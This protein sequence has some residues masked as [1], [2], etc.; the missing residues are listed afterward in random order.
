[1]VNFLF[2]H[3][4]TTQETT[5]NPFP[6]HAKDHDLF[7]RIEKEVP[8]LALGSGN[9]GPTSWPAELEKLSDAELLG[10][11]AADPEMAR[12]V[13]SGLLL[14]ADLLDES[15]SI[16]QEI[17]TP[18]GSYWHGIMH[19][20]EGDF[21]NSKYWFRRVGSHGLFPELAEEA[22]ALE[23]EA[24][25]KVQSG[26]TWDPDLFVDLCESRHARKRDQLTE[27]LEDLQ[28]LEIRLL[29]EYSYRMAVNG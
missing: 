20:R 27:D 11:D 19:R 17:K 28:E 29:L 3:T 5:M 16:S 26:G 2:E 14:R 6:E 25:K 1:M 8:R 23:S 12:A 15:H 22:E 21:S 4:K 18:T 7:E 24:G 10:A 9:H 13:R